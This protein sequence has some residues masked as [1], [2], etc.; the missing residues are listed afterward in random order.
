MAPPSAVPHLLP[1]GQPPST[2]QVTTLFPGPA[3]ASKRNSPQRGLAITGPQE[4]AHAHPE[5]LQP[6]GSTGLGEAKHLLE[7]SVPHG[8]ISRWISNDDLLLISNKFVWRYVGDTLVNY[9][10]TIIKMRGDAN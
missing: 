2:L 5:L 3:D 6:W 4:S 7:F 1:E 9:S 8:I 10:K